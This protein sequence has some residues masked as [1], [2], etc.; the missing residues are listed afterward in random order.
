[1]QAGIY[2]IFLSNCSKQII[3]Q[4]NVKNHR[5]VCLFSAEAIFF[6]QREAKVSLENYADRLYFVFFGRICINFVRIRASQI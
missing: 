4:C 5:Y 3:A 6:T 1:M 2:I